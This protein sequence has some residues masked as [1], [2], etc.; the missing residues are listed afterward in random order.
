MT[1]SRVDVCCGCSL[2]FDSRVNCCAEATCISTAMKTRV[3]VDKL[4]ISFLLYRFGGIPRY[5]KIII[6]II[7]FKMKIIYKRIPLSFE[8]FLACSDFCSSSPSQSEIFILLHV[9]Q[10]FIIIII[11]CYIFCFYY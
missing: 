11:F 6:F 1:L 5:K 10:H 3:C 9:L 7:I 8:S 2:S 4:I